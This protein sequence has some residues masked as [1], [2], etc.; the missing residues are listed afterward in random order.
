MWVFSHIHPVSHLCSLVSQPPCWATVL[1]LHTVFASQGSEENTVVYVVGKA[2]RQHWQ[3]VYTAVTRG[4]SRVY[5][6]AQESELRRAIWKRSFPR[7]TRL[8]HFLQKKLSSECASP[9]HFP[10]QPSSPG[11]GG[12]PCTQPP[13]SPLCR[14]LDSIA[15]R[16][17]ASSATKGRLSFDERWLSASFNDMDTDDESTQPRGS[18]RTGDGFPFDDESPS[19]FRMVGAMFPC[20]HVFFQSCQLQYAWARPCASASVSLCVSTSEQLVYCV[21]QSTPSVPSSHPS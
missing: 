4:R 14:A 8:K 1:S 6:I 21:F 5:V 10:S 3:H 11:V 20:V 17:E 13:A 12:R 2:G 19:K 9:T 18:K 16:D 15:T 7:K